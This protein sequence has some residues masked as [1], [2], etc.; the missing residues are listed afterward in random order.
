MNAAGSQIRAKSAGSAGGSAPH[1][2]AAAAVAVGATSIHFTACFVDGHTLTSLAEQSVLLGLGAVVDREGEIPAG[3]LSELVAILVRFTANAAALEC[4]DLTFV[5]TEPLR[6]AANSMAARAEIE[7]ATGRPTHVLSHE[8]EG[9][10]S[11]LGVTGG[12]PPTAE[13]LVVD[14]GGGSSE[15]VVAGP[16]HAPRA[17]G[18]RVGAARLT[19]AIVGHDPPQRQEVEALRAEACRRVT[20]AGD[21]HPAMATFVG[22]TASNLVK[23][24]PAAALDRILTLDRIASAFETLERERA[25]LTAA[26]F[27]IHPARARILPG[28]AAIVEAFLL[29][30]AMSRAGVSEASIREG[31]I[32]A[33]GHAGSAWRESI[34]ALAAGWTA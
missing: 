24:V 23:V 34:A 20:E 8:E 31:V 16:G 12:I 26:R 32:L 7:A 1:A 15:Y 30:Y 28:G 4:R 6:R 33:V 29:R 21:L 13:H 9:L 22:G 10:L 18:L 5:A 19:D 11:L 25:E 27:G 2:A 17:G 3:I 14:I